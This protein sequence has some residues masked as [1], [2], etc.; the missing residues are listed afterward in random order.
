M[1]KQ[2]TR[3]CL[4]IGCGKNKRSGFIGIDK[5]KAPAVDIVLDLETEKLPFENETIDYVVADSFLEHLNS[6]EF[7]L[8]E[9]WRVMKKEAVFE[10]TVPYYR[11]SVEAQPYH[12]LRFG[13]TSFDSD[14]HR[15]LQDKNFFEIIERKLVFRG[16]DFFGLIPFIAEKNYCVYERWLSHFFPARQIKW[17]LKKEVE[18]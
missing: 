1:K 3:L 9:A 11:N 5:F 10:V 6:I 15:S 13:W 8:S 2:D 16:L 7:V 18:K 4:D 14:K 17:L 12:R